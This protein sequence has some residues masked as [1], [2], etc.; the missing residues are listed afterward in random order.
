MGKRV[1]RS[2]QYFF[3]GRYSADNG[4]N[5]INA[6]GFGGNI[7]AKGGN[8][9]VNVG[10]FSATVHTGSGND[11]VNGAAGRL[12]V[13]DDSGHLRVNGAAGRVD[14]RKRYSGNITFRGAAG[15]VTI[16]HHGWSG[17]IDFA[18]AAFRNVVKRTG[19]RG[20]VT[21]RGAGGSNEIVH[22]TETGNTLF[23][24]AGASNVV[25]RLS[26]HDYH[27]SRGNVTF[28]GAGARNRVENRVKFGNLT[29]EGAGVSNVV[30]REAGGGT[31][32]GDV[33]FRGAGANNQILHYTN[34]G[35]TLFE[36]AG[37]ANFVKR[38]SRGNYHT[39]SGDVT[40]RGAGARNRVENRVK[41]GNLTFEGAGASNVIKREGG[42]GA[43]SKG[44]V[45]FR[46]AGAGNQI[47]HKTNQ[48]DTLFEGAGASNFVKRDWQGIYNTS[49]GDVTFRG[50]GVSNRVE[51]WVKHGN[52][53]FEGAG[54][55]NI[56]RRQG[57]AGGWSSGNVTF[58]GAGAA[59]VVTHATQTGNTE[60]VGAGAANVVIRS[61]G[62]GSRGNVT[63][64]GAGVGNALTHTTDHGDLTFQGGGGAN[65][66]TRLGVTGDVTFQGAGGVNV[67]THDT[68]SGDTLFQ[69]VGA[70]NVV[71]R[72]GGRGSRG[73]ITFQ[74]AG[75]G[76]VVTHTTDHGDLL[77]QGGGGANV[78]TRLGVTGD[79]TFQ[80][81]GAANV[82]TRTGGSGSV[83]DVTFQGAGVGN[84]VTH[85]TDHGDL[86]FQG[87]GGANVVTRLGTT[88]DL[89]F[90]GAGA[91]NA[92]TQ[93]VDRG[94]MEVVA[95]GGANVVTRSGDGDT[96]LILA[97]DTN[98]ANVA[99][100]GD[101][102]AVMVGRG[103][104]LGTDVTGKTDAVLVGGANVANVAGKADIKAFGVANV[105]TTG[106]HADDIT[107]FGAYNVIKTGGIGND[108]K[109][110]GGFST[111]IYEDQGDAVSSGA[112]AETDTEESGDDPFSS[113]LD[114]LSEMT[115]GA[116]SG[117]GLPADAGAEES[118]AATASALDGF[119][120]EPEDDDEEG[121]EAGAAGTEDMALSEADIAELEAGGIDIDARLES[122]GRS[123]SDLDAGS[124]AADPETLAA[125]AGGLP[126]FDAMMAAN[127]EALSLE[128]T[129]EESFL[130]SRESRTEGM[131]G[132]AGAADPIL[133]DMNRNG[134]LDLVDFDSSGVSYDFGDG[135]GEVRTAWTGKGEDIDGFLTRKV[136]DGY[137]IRFARDGMDETDMEGLRAEVGDSLD[138]EDA[139]YDEF[140][141]WRDTDQDG[142]VDEGEFETLADAGIT[143]VDL[144]GER[145]AAT[146]IVSDSE[147]HR[148]GNTFTL[149][150][151]TLG[152]Y[153]V[154]LRTLKLDAAGEWAYD[155]IGE[156][157]TDGGTT[158][159]GA[160]GGQRWSI[161]GTHYDTFTLS[162]GLG[163]FVRTGSEKDII[164]AIS[165]VNAIW[166]GA[167]D[168]FV[169]T[170]GLGNYVDAGDGNDWGLMLGLANYF[171]GGAGNDVAIQV[172]YGNVARMGGGGEDT[173]VQLGRF[174]LVTK[175]ED[176]DLY[177]GMLGQANVLYHGAF[178]DGGD[179][180]VEGDLLAVMVGQLNVAH[181]QGDGNVQV[182]MGGLIQSASQ[183][184]DGNFT[185]VMGG[186][187]NVAT[188]VGDGNMVAV[189]LGQG[190]IATRVGDGQSNL[191]MLGKYNVATVVGDGEL[192]GI[193]GGQANVVTKVG[194]GLV[195][196]GMAGKYNVA[197]IVN[198]QGK[199]DSETNPEAS[200]LWIAFGGK[201]NFVSKIGDGN[202]YA[203]G[204][205]STGNV[206][207]QI[208]DGD[209]V[210]I[211]TGKTNVVLKV[212]DAKSKDYSAMVLFGSHN[213]M[214]NAADNTDDYFSGNVNNTS[215]FFAYGKANLAVR[216]GDGHVISLMGGRG[217]VT[218]HIG[219][220]NLWGFNYASSK[221]SGT[222]VNGGGG[223]DGGGN[224]DNAGADGEADANNRQEGEKSSLDQLLE[225]I[226]SP[227]IGAGDDVAAGHEVD[228][229]R[230]YEIRGHAFRRYWNPLPASLVGSFSNMLGDLAEGFEKSTSLKP[231]SVSNVTKGLSSSAV[232]FAET[233][234]NTK[235][236]IGDGAGSSEANGNLTLKVG[237]GD[238][239]FA[240][241]A[242]SD[243]DIHFY[244]SDSELRGKEGLDRAKASGAIGNF[245]GS[246][247]DTVKHA[248]T[249][250][251]AT[252]ANLGESLKA[253]LT[254]GATPSAN[255]LV[256]VGN[257]K[258]RTLQYG[259]NNV[260]VKVGH[261][262]RT[263]DFGSLAD[264]WRP[265]VVN[266]AWGNN[267]IAFEVNA[268]SIFKQSTYR[269]TSGGPSYAT[270]SLQAMVGSHNM[271]V[272]V[273][274]GPTIRALIGNLNLSVTVGNGP[275]VAA[276]MGHGNLLVRVNSFEE[277]PDGIQGPS[278]GRLILGRKNLSF[279]FGNSNDV[280]IFAPNSWDDVTTAFSPSEKKESN[281]T[282]NPMTLQERI[283]A[284]AL[285]GASIF[286]LGFALPSLSMK[287]P[288]V[289]GRG[290]PKLDSDGNPDTEATSKYQSR[291][292]STQ[293]GKLWEA[294]SNP[295]KAA[296]DF[297]K[298]TNAL[299]T[300][301]YDYVPNSH[302]SEEEQ[303]EEDPNR[304]NDGREILDA[305]W[306]MNY[307]ITDAMAHGSANLV[308]A[309]GGSD[310]V[311][312][313]GHGNMVFGDYMTSLLDMSIAS[314]FPANGQAISLNEFLEMIRAARNPNSD[315]GRLETLVDGFQNFG[316]VGFT[317]PYASFGEM[318]G[319]S[320]TANGQTDGDVDWK[321]FGTY[322]ARMGWFEFTLP[323]SV[324]GSFAGAFTGFS[325]NSIV[326]SVKDNAFD[327][328]NS[329]DWGGDGFE[330][331]NSAFDYDADGIDLEDHKVSTDITSGGLS[332]SND[333]PFFPADGLPVIAAIPNFQSM[334]TLFLNFGEVL[335]WG[336][337]GPLDNLGELFMNM[338]PLEEQGDILVS[339]G[340]ANMLFGG[341]GD[342]IIVGTGN[343]SRAFG[344]EGDDVMALL[345]K[346]N[347]LGGNA[348]NDMMLAI[349][350]MN[351]VHDTDGNN[352]VLAFAKK[353]DIRMGRGND[354]IVVY[355]D[356]N[357]ARTGT[358]FDFV[359][360]A[361]N[362]NSI[363][364]AGDSVVYGFGAENNYYILGGEGNKS[365]IYNFGSAKITLSPGGKAF[366]E[367][368]GG[369]IFGSS[370]DDFIS[371][372]RGSQGGN[373]FGDDR[374]DQIG[375]DNRSKD[376]I[377]MRGRDTVAWGGNG[378]TGDQDVFIVGYG[379]KDGVIQEAGGTKLGF[380]DETE[381][382]IVLGERIGAAD[383]S[384]S[385][386]EAPIQFERE[387]DDLIILMPDHAIFGGNPAP[388]DADRLN[389]VRIEGY[390]SWGGA[391][392]AQI[393][394]SIW[395]ENFNDGVRAAWQTAHD[396]EEALKEQQ[397]GY[398]IHTWSAHTFS[399]YTYLTRDG[400]R[401]LMEAFS[402]TTG[403]DAADRWAKVW[404]SQWDEQ[405]GTWK[406]TSKVKTGR[407]L[408]DFKLAQTQGLMIAGG[409][410]ADAIDGTSL[411]DVIEG[412][413]GD[414]VLQGGAGGDVLFGG[415]GDD[416]L[417]GGDGDDTLSGGAGDDTLAGGA[418]DDTVDY[419]YLTDGGVQVDLAN[420]TATAAG[421]TDSL[422]GIENVVGS[423]GNDRLTGDESDNLLTG[424]AGD[425]TLEGGGGIDTV[426]Y[427]YVSDGGVAV[428]LAS[429]TATTKAAAGGDS[430]ILSGVENVLGSRYDDTLTGNADGNF[431]A[432]EAGDDILS[433]GAGNDT[434]T[435][436]S[437]SDTYLFGRGDGLDTIDDAGN[438][439]GS[440]DMVC[441]GT[442]I[443]TDQLWFM[444]S[445]DDLSVS[446]VG[447]AD[448]LL[449]DDWYLGAQHRVDAFELETGESLEAAQVQSLVDAMAAF[450][451]PPPGSERIPPATMDQ[452]GSTIAGAWTPS[453]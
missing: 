152:A 294:I 25:K 162:G 315:S 32:E 289:D 144:S 442:G 102:D 396:A 431:L 221:G 43:T 400:V 30:R 384:G 390:F 357:K 156:I 260:M 26:N 297:G 450:G 402:N 180:M 179:S 194:T 48:G 284:Y 65:V 398:A 107:A 403:T 139:A 147:V 190:N 409:V 239:T 359:I 90:H 187:L 128:G 163:N 363:Y 117:E 322:L 282:S 216:A 92:I 113:I 19:K 46:G 433:G 414:D 135:R 354:V 12:N 307:T 421:E 54:A 36:G 205:G 432:G 206:L 326:N 339:F 51:S 334:M 129:T 39:S 316:D 123:R 136:G 34:Q 121:D 217:N 356:K 213:I 350:E 88:G 328:S 70:A 443:A 261:A 75:V 203:L 452:L 185:A 312:T 103:N 44:E 99:G 417:Y 364:L 386:L 45:T 264:Y 2:V 31:S 424:L 321:Q 449:I 437:G 381:D 212:G 245:L 126:D 379:L 265:D 83:G 119:G 439:A 59:N 229:T 259:S 441:F 373:L 235:N 448:A 352:T 327:W 16:D 4:N 71:T 157:A 98:V 374:L 270:S 428:D 413:A 112:G 338:K 73:N 196:I 8:D 423:A 132:G 134:Q 72:T 52:L 148:S 167:G 138:S 220:G 366:V 323:S 320:V 370:G 77:F 404:N 85:T 324:F 91:A 331:A 171:H 133:L 422:S 355:G 177:A 1:R 257:G 3:T 67:V 385:I 430:D 127:A 274:D 332:E 140:G 42:G 266:L 277:Q 61:G 189:M 169:I 256:Q 38:D 141:V 142:E 87:G 252:L 406:E 288:K 387:G 435:G 23:E 302:A 84:V 420:G 86:L 37:A 165:A 114:G 218:F 351:V 227:I 453:V 11:T 74:G 405:A 199:T 344:G 285:Q 131:D 57:G 56:V 159:T 226:F 298:W 40:F 155:N 401:T 153:D 249:N 120:T 341:H 329:L 195:G 27:A 111:V 29:F 143:D 377:L 232:N 225:F 360:A 192:H 6:F 250:P 290:Q 154:S 318:L 378:G 425:D 68:Q 445:G 278:G 310:I 314:F 446:I 418:G 146:A 311:I 269:P 9:T 440:T 268:D 337:G 246:V 60:F 389:S 58:R 17:S 236:E 53:L 391:Q 342:D 272:K 149:N 122:M 28:R 436:G 7:Y 69:G 231:N 207:A 186:R 254:D 49:R 197:T 286:G 201:F 118:A 151:E 415:A 407:G 255:L 427:G 93:Q 219:D 362:K 240:Q 193:F 160:G 271:S 244:D 275:D 80:G 109:A 222:G 224:D 184:G 251:Q 202:T 388:L 158:A 137:Q 336:E 283:K 253:E 94:D 14:I 200:D 369:E 345:G 175:E 317:I 397:N 24:G 295:K 182:Y 145:D 168:D 101:V 447:Q 367:A 5:R 429:G 305:M 291:L 79:V 176:G 172:G 209:L 306:E 325:I 97:G 292:A 104:Y 183:K 395:D 394:L 333:A 198:E 383:Y 35:D 21:F 376:T 343:V 166:S 115:G 124:A 301:K 438:D 100:A 106:D 281:D 267:N 358:G 161:G 238:V 273:G 116:I 419:S 95:V 41:F 82:V 22:K 276:V 20:H 66:V 340:A 204:Y 174:N 263:E 50:A 62:R 243:F 372:G 237:D 392:A 335:S 313:V 382:K 371:F 55:S 353:N 242:R 348:G 214:V 150:G 426:D 293:A 96:S 434:L 303:R 262:G 170:A 191:F 33:T 451:A 47:L 346:Y 125:S 234:R 10:S 296:S 81:A 13:R 64:Q 105:I 393:L 412:G 408:S 208:G 164:L 130:E 15:K 230:A 211:L 411:D 380:G 308:Q 78:L 300:G 368:L 215:V 258:T 416:T 188:K 279:D 287:K 89:I 444:Q 247:K 233:I 181:R 280:M 349:G 223:N 110:L 76:N 375:L 210:A 410:G 309:G 347:Y 108:V 304:P 248:V 319:V 361:G 228:N 365:L 399:H 18:G 63:F 330:Q 241:I 299:K 178:A 173:A